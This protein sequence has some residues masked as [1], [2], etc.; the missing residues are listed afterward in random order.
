M[1]KKALLCLLISCS[2]L[3]VVHAQK[4]S[5]LFKINDQPYYADAF[6]QSYLKNLDIVQE[7]QQ[8]DPDVYLD[9]YID[10]QIKLLKAKELGLDQQQAFIDE[11][12]RY[13]NQLAN[14][15]LTNV[16]ITD[17]LVKEAY[18]RSLYELDAS[19]ILVGIPKGAQPADTLAAF[20]KIKAIKN[21]IEQGENFNLVAQEVSE[22]PS[23][24]TN[25]GKLG[26]F[27]T[28]D[29]VFEFEDAAYQLE[30]GQTS[31][32]VKTS[33]GYHLIQLHQK[34]KNRGEINVAHILIRE[35][36]DPAKAEEKIRSIYEEIKNGLAFERA[37]QKYSDDNTTASRGGKL[38]TLRSG[39]INSPTFEETIFALENPEQISEPFKTKFGWHIVKLL[40]KPGMPTYEASR[41]RIKERIK[42][43]RR[44]VIVESA[45]VD[46]LEGIYSVKQDLNAV[47]K[48]S[49]YFNEDLLI[50]KFIQKNLP[51]FSEETIFSIEK[52]NIPYS[53]FID[54]AKQMQLK[55]N[56]YISLS[57]MLEAYYERFYN[58]RLIDYHK[59]NL[60]A[61]NPEFKSI[62]TDYH[63][64][65]LVFEL[66]NQQIWEKAK[67]DSIGLEQFY[68]L[69][70]SNY[71]WNKKVDATLYTLTSKEAADQAYQ[72]LNNKA[73]EEEIKQKLNDGNRISVL[74]SKGVTEADNPSFPKSF[75]P[76][77]GISKPLTDDNKNYKIVVVHE[78]EENAQKSFKDAKSQVIND[79][80]LYLEK[81]WNQNLR[82]GYTIIVDIKNFKKLKKSL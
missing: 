43:D 25:K 33:F 19:H 49:N 23:A 50:G 79:Y 29:M 65:M 15:Y 54:F 41:D 26:W 6:K 46:E 14:A 28:F 77:V 62:V 21:R 78:L 30:P 18:D 44:Y 16:E 67:T 59:N 74:I 55:D 80:Q 36:G 9:L 71:T 57:G 11:F 4:S 22:D 66:M 63:D 76:A 35:E 69:N 40:D 24:R 34:R 31:E 17:N 3:S 2:F 5:L 20:E 52:T 51:E 45:L 47:E 61:V 53:E 72:L 7:E 1:H 68:N 8:K 56:N 39:N 75:S 64:G 13:R 32:I 60:E 73:S 81:E 10:Y 82:K 42:R 12:T 27:S 37:A 70:K 48:L 58:Q 38:A